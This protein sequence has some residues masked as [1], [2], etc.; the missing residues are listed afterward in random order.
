MSRNP[1]EPRLAVIIDADNVSAAPI[2]ELIAEISRHGTPTVRRIY[3]DW[4]QQNMTQWKNVLHEH[5]ITPVQQYRNTIGKNAS[6]S[7][8]IIDAMDILYAGNVEGFCIVSSDADFTRLA[9]RLRE[10][11]LRVLGFGAKHTPRPFVAACEQFIYLEVLKDSTA[12]AQAAAKPGNG[13]GGNGSGNGGNGNGNSTTPAPSGPTPEPVRTG[14]AE[15]PVIEQMIITIVDD[16]ADEDGWASL[17]AVGTQL[18][19]QEPDFDT[20]LYGYPKLS[21]LIEA[22]PDFELGKQESSSGRGFSYF[23]RRAE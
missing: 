13:N 1:S 15:L 17:G 11:G 22:L 3:G 7:A 10:A 5:A 23:V 18:L 20:R 4:T 21:R 12:P 2:R 19:K 16:L 8:M 6:D 14:P 9:T